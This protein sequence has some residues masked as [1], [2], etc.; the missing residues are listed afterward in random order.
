MKTAVLILAAV[1]A[2]AV[3]VAVAVAVT[4]V[5]AMLKYDP[6]ADLPKNERK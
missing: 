5:L 2:L 4:I 3:I 6:A 1:L